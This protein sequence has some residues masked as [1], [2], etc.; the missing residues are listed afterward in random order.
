MDARLQGLH[1]RL[2]PIQRNFCCCDRVAA[3]M[4][5]CPSP[6]ACGT[7]SQ[8]S[9]PCNFVTSFSRAACRA[10]S[11]SGSCKSEPAAFNSVFVSKVLHD[12]SV[13]ANVSGSTRAWVSRSLAR[14]PGC[15]DARADVNVSS[16]YATSWAPPPSDLL[17]TSL[18]GISESAVGSASCSSG[19]STESSYLYGDKRAPRAVARPLRDNSG[20]LVLRA[21][22]V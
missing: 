17:V 13:N 21:P 10:D 16:Q 19:C 18:F 7:C 1:V 14:F 5:S 6:S 20:E 22:G 4:V 3:K 12:S 9:N 15:L 11:G 8:V 2:S